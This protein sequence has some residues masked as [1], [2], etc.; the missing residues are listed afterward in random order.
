MFVDPFVQSNFSGPSHFGLNFI[1]TE[2]IESVRTG[3]DWIELP[4]T[5]VFPIESSIERVELRKYIE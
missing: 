3:Y 5:F 2:V 4:I 1:E